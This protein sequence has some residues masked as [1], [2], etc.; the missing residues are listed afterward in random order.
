MNIVIYGT[1]GVGGYFGARLSQAGNNVTFIARGKHLEAI[2]KNGLQ[3]KSHKGDYLVKPANVSSTITD[4]K[5]IDLIL[6]C[7]KTWQL[8]EVAEKIK[9]VLTEN[10]MVISL[11]NGVENQDVLCS[12]IGKKH[13]LAGLCLVVSKVEDYGLINHLSYEPTIVFGELN[14]EKTA[15]AL[16]LE[17]VFCEANITNKLAQNIQIEY[18]YRYL[19]SGVDTSTNWFS[20]N[21]MWD[22]PSGQQVWAYADE[23]DSIGLK[24][25]WV[26]YSLQEDAGVDGSRIAAVGYGSSKPIASNKTPQGRQKNRR[27]EFKVN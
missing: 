27:V 5:N 8:S 17:K 13:I 3:L 6:V 12:I 20:W 9:P 14:N 15:R 10:T 18:R 22:K 21:W 19:C 4:I 23:A 7:V 24:P 26:V 2:Q 25:A 11:L 16:W 1:G